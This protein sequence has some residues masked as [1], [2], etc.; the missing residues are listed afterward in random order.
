MKT[1]LITGGSRG[2]GWGISLHLAKENYNIIFCGRRA[3][4]EVTEQVD[5]L[6]QQGVGVLYRQCDISDKESRMAMIEEADKKFGKIDVLINNAGVAPEERKDLLEASEESFDK[7][8]SI[9]LKGPY[10]LSQAVANYMLS[11][12]TEGIIINITS[13]SS[14]IA[15]VNRGEYCVSKAGLSMMTKL[16][17]TRL[18]EH[19]INVY[20]IQ[21]GIIETD[22]TKG[23]KAKYDDLID[24]GLTLNKRWGQPE[25]IAKAVS[26]L[27]RGDFPYSTGNIFMIDGG[28]TVGRL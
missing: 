16:F 3:Q 4:E 26:A 20:E 19:N 7:L 1:A 24:K 12:K 13:I 25:D 6:E 23:V 10:F 11:K 22:M 14:S 2:I 5:L 18:A 21:P 27:C 17:A 28:L 8:I 9:N 15:S